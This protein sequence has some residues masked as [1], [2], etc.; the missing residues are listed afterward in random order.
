MKKTLTAAIAVLALAAVAG[1][2]IIGCADHMR[3]VT[4][5]ENQAAPAPPPA[6]LFA[7]DGGGGW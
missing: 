1:V 4:T 5:A 6:P 3:P 7:K 2:S